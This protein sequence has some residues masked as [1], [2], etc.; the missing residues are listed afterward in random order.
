MLGMSMV[1]KPWPS[2]G[3]LDSGQL[4]GADCRHGRPSRHLLGMGRLSRRRT[5]FRHSGSGYWRG[6]RRAKLDS[7]IATRVLCIVTL[8]E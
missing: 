4:G 5:G 2:S 8:W 6:R 1:T 7:W 3:T